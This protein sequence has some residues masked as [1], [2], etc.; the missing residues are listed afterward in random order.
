MLTSFMN[1]PLTIGRAGTDGH[2]QDGKWV[3]ATLATPFDIL[4]SI[5]PFKR[6]T[7]Q[8]ILPEGIKASDALWVWTVTA[9]NTVNQFNATTA[10]TTDID[11]REYTAFDVEN[12]SRHPS[13]SLNHYKVLMV[14]SDKVRNGSLG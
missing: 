1:I 2:Y 5:Q 7:S 4:C 13:L 3:K 10:D 11:G 12:W 8:D 9:L 14:R 6:G